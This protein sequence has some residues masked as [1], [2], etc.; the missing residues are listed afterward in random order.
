MTSGSLKKYKRE[1]KK[2]LES[3][4]NRNITYQNLWVTAKTV[5]IGKFIAMS[6]YIKKRK[7]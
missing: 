5:L 3:N 1:I 7:G 2:Y 4:E 6:A